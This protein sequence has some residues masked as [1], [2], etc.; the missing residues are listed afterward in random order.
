MVNILPN[1]V[2]TF[3]NRGQQLSVLHCFHYVQ[4]HFLYHVLLY[5]S[6]PKSCPMSCLILCPIPCLMSYHLPSTMTLLI[7]YSMS[8]VMSKVHEES[9]ELLAISG[10]LKSPF[11]AFSGSELWWDLFGVFGGIKQPKLGYVRGLKRTHFGIFRGL[12]TTLFGIFRG[13][14]ILK[15]FWSFQEP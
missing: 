7:S 3:C 6:F 12:K 14:K 10:A 8:D 2:A 5:D 15:P 9:L 4:C 11:L 1:S 13:L